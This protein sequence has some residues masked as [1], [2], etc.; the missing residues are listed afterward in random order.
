MKSDK[1]ITALNRYIEDCFLQPGMQRQHLSGAG[2]TFLLEKK[3]RNFYGKKFTVTFCNATTALLTLSIALGLEN[4]EI[5]TSSVNWGGSIA[6]FLLNKNKLHFTSVDSASLNLDVND[7][8]SAISQKT[9]AVMSVDYNGKALDSRA[10]KNFC[11]INNLKYISDSAQSLGAYHNGKPAGYYADAVVLSFSPGKTFFGGEGGAVLTNDE[12]LYEKILWL[13]QHPERQ[14]A[15]FGINNYN[16]YAPFN[17]RMNPLSAILLNETFESSLA[18]L[19]IY[20][21]KCYKLLINLSYAKLVELPT[22]ITSFTSSTFFN[23]SLRLKP[24]IK[25]NHVNEY[26]KDNE[27]PFTTVRY[28]PKLIPFDSYFRKYFKEKYSCTKRL[29]EQVS[30]FQSINWITLNNST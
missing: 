20:Q 7:L 26:L 5:I 6:P 19:K 10:I 24:T 25:L 3:L 11:T 21:K 23:F 27:Q 12:A 16:E 17:G 13:S 9:K 8:S 29:S 4:S 2:A 30:S 18:A 14:K 28:F 15:V 22:H 1:T